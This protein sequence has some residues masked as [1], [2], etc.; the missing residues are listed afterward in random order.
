MDTREFKTKTKRK[1]EKDSG[2]GVCLGFVL[3]QNM[4]PHTAQVQKDKVA[5]P[6]LSW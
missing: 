3:S 1:K 6:I 4:S 5:N 2:I